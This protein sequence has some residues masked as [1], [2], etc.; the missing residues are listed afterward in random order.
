MLRLILIPLDDIIRYKF[1][2]ILKRYNVIHSDA[3]HLSAVMDWL[4]RSHNVTNGQG[5]SKG[6]SLLFRWLPAYPETTGYLIP[7]FFDY[8]LFTG[9][10]RFAEQAYQMSDWLVRVQFHDGGCIQGTVNGRNPRSIVFNTGQM[11]LGL[12]RTYKETKEDN[13]IKAAVRA[14]DFLVNCIDDKG[15]YSKNLFN[16]IVHTYNARCSWALLELYLITDD[17]KYKDY[18]I[19]N[20]NWTIDQQLENGWYKSNTFKPDSFPNTHS[21][22]YPTRGMLESYRILKMEN[23]LQAARK[24]AEKM[25][26]LFEIRGWISATHTNEWKYKSFYVCVTGN[27]QFSIIWM[28]LYE[29]VK[30]ARFLNAALKAVDFAK[31]VQNLSTKNDNIRGAI[32]GSQPIFGRY[33]PLK[34]P[35]WAA[36]FFADSLIL[37]TRIMKALQDEQTQDNSGVKIS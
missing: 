36:K 14:G 21:I 37:K 34:Y 30:D 11:L 28:K 35:N 33:A 3:E 13:F 20:L 31:T 4:E 5:S 17:A 10:A 1:G 27:I 15:C 22:A 32:K 19:R 29:L 25:M 8:A 7:T 26:R 18:A 23:Y 24:T 2:R 16:G 12:V 9:N 6:Y